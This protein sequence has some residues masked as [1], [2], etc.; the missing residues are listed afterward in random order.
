MPVTKD[1]QVLLQCKRDVMEGLW[2]VPLQSLY[3][4]THQSNHLHQFNRKENA[5]GYLHAAA[6]SPVQD[7]WS[8]SVNWGYFNTWP[9]LRAKDIHNMNKYEAKIKGHLVQSKEI[10]NQQQPTRALEK[11]SCTIIQYKN[12]ITTIQNS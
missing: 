12:Q 1:E 3:R 9:V 5:M 6:F 2:R 7:T 11:N 8:K 10:S 4:P